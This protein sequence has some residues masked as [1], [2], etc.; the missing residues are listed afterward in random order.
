MPRKRY[1]PKEIVLKL[2]QVDVLTSQGQ[3]VSDAIRQI[4][5]TKVTAGLYGALN[6]D[7]R[8]T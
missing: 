6:H 2:R 1:K 3:G 5:V 7:Y 4:G 8:L